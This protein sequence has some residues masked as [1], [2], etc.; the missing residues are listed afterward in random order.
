MSG[1]VNFC[2]DCGQETADGVKTKHASAT[3]YTILRDPDHNGWI[4]YTG[5]DDW[6]P[7]YTITTN[8]E[9]AVLTDDEFQIHDVERQWCSGRRLIRERV[10]VT[11]TTTTTY[12]IAGG[13][14]DSVYTKSTNWEVD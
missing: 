3:T 11:V 1:G 5:S 14:K 6:G 9:E 10:T 8:I 2:H 12:E 4:G 7:R 13:R